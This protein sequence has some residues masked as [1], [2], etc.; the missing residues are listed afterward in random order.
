MSKKL[1]KKNRYMKKKEEGRRQATLGQRF[2]GG[3]VKEKV[4]DS[5]AKVWRRTFFL[6]GVS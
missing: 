5:W 1:K 6:S 4:G 3:A 2:G